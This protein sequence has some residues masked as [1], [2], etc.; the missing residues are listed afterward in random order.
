[1]ALKI[2]HA[3]KAYVIVDS[4]SQEQPRLNLMRII[5]RLR[6]ELVQVLN[7][8]DKVKAELIL[9]KQAAQRQS[10][11]LA[12]VD[13]ALGEFYAPV[14]DPETEE[15]CGSFWKDHGVNVAMQVLE[16]ERLRAEHAEA[17]AQL[18]TPELA[19]LLEWLANNVLRTGVYPQYED[20][21]AHEARELAA[22]IR[23]ALAQEKTE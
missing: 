19:A 12:A 16:T 4:E 1:M 8:R 17:L 3:E 7:E 14:L 18:V 15:P 13:E 11:E 20:T 10:E 9:I 22:S 23:A 2:I 5:V 21:R 6:A